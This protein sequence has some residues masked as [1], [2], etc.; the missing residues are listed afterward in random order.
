MFWNG[1]LLLQEGSPES[2]FQW[3]K[4]CVNL[5]KLLTMGVICIIS[6]NQ[7]PEAF[8]KNHFKNSTI[9]LS[10]LAQ[11]KKIMVDNEPPSAL[12]FDDYFAVKST[13]R[14]T[15]SKIARELASTSVFHLSPKNVFGQN[16]VSRV[17]YH[18]F[19]NTFINEVTTLFQNTSS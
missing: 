10:S 14:E 13:S 7:L 19:S 8:W 15:L 6:N 16:E 12:I 9:Q 3:F 18:S 4:P 1:S 11:I 5:F 17:R 2:D